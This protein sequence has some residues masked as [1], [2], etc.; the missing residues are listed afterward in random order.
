[1]K[2]YVVFSKEHYD[3]LLQIFSYDNFFLLKTLCSFCDSEE[4]AQTI[5]GIFYKEDQKHNDIILDFIQELLLVHWQSKD[6]TSKEV[7]LRRGKVFISIN[8]INAFFTIMLDIMPIRVIRSYFRLV[9]AEYLRDTIYP[10]IQNVL[11]DHPDVEID[12]LKITFPERL[13][14]NINRLLHTSQQ[15]FDCIMKSVSSLPMLK[16]PNFLSFFFL[17]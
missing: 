12:P 6:D 11:R 13:E 7:F 17:I 2:R 3:E 16:E 8:L 15:F 1:M 9:G 4:L 14:A 5:V 10:L